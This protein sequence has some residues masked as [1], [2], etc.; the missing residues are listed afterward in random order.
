M[1]RA[2]LQLLLATVLGVL[3]VSA[4]S[5]PAKVTKIYT[6]E[7]FVGPLDK[8]LILGVH[9][10]RNTRAKFERALVNA[11]VERGGN[12]RAI[13]S[14]MGTDTALDETIVR[15]V[16]REIAADAV[17]V[18]RVKSSESEVELSEGRTE[19]RVDRKDERLVDFF[20]YDYTDIPDP[21]EIKLKRTVVLATDLYA[22]DAGKKIWSIESTSFD[23]DDVADVIDDEVNA[24]ARQLS[25]DGLI[26]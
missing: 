1:K 14:E 17:L 11:I 4:C 25:R 7:S 24:I 10:D 18:T 3:V 15:R 16:A 8:L 22:R 6:D 26:P 2:P 12:A 19:V 13:S 20:R 5:T 9:D 21:D 23:R